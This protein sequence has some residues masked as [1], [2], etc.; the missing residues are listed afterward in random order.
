M[1]IESDLARSMQQIEDVNGGFI[2]PQ[3][4]RPNEFMCFAIDNIDF[5]EATWSGKNSLHGTGLCVF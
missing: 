5:N 3:W 1:Q 2:A 4:L